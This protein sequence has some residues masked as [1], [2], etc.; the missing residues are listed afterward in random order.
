MI[1]LCRE[2]STQVYP[3][4]IRSTQPARISLNK[5]SLNPNGDGPDHK[6]V[7]LKHLGSEDAPAP[8]LEMS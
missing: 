8:S 2:G 6:W 1:G 7:V 5:N 3:D 4:A